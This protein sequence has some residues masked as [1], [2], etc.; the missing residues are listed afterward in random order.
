VALALFADA[1]TDA[2]S[3]RRFANDPLELFKELLSQRGSSFE[4]LDAEVQQAFTD[5]FGDLSYEELRLLARLQST[6][7]GVNPEHGLNERV[8][9][10]SFVTLA[11][12]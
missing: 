1:I 12:L 9:V 4:E 10:G 5:L 8:E 2:P 3:R 7:G 6:L 11:K